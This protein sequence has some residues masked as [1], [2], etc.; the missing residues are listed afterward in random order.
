MTGA[1]DL[2]QRRWPHLRALLL[3]LL[4]LLGASFLGG[5]GVPRLPELPAPGASQTGA[6]DP[7]DST[8]V[9]A[10]E[11][12]TGPGCFQRHLREAISLNERR[13]RVYVGWTDGASAPISRRLIRAERWALPVAWYVDRRAEPFQEAGIPIGCAEFVSMSLTPPL[14]GAAEAIPGVPYSPGPD[15]DSLVQA[16]AAAYGIG[17][18]PEVA[19]TTEALLDDLGTA[20]DYHCMVRHLL[21]STWRVAVL[22][23]AHAAAAEAAGLP[24]TLA[25]SSLLLRLHLAALPDG[26][27]LDREA[28]PLQSAGV[29]IICRDVPPIRHSH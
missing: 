5:C 14:D 26:A 3:G 16:I 25:L 12:E 29:P 28:A 6:S 21:E 13:A 18:F 7:G 22:A 24:P 2:L 9:I 1:T 15:P 23:P 19:A 27:R 4:L 8:P 20:P 17:G 11:S 10:D